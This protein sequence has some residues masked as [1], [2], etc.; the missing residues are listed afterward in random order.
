MNYRKRKKFLTKGLRIAQARLDNNILDSSARRAYEFY[1]RW[2]VYL[3]ED[4]NETRK[5]KASTT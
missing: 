1:Y 2:L 4:R 5:T 3:K